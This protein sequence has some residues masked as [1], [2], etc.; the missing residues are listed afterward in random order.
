MR[1]GFRSIPACVLAALALGLALSAPAGAVTVGQTATT[2][3]GTCSSGIVFAQPSSASPS[4]TIPAGGG[5]IDHWS[6]ATFGATPGASVSLLVLTQLSATMYQVD[7][8]DNAAL[9]NPLPTPAGSAV[10]FTPATPIQAPAGA[11]LGL[12]GGTPSG[13]ECVFA[14]GANDSY[15]VGGP[16]SA[17]ANVASYTFPNPPSTGE[18]LNVAAD[19]VQN[20]DAG[21]TT[22]VAPSTATA[23]GVAAFTFT[24]TNSGVSTGTA[25]FSD[26]IP[27][28]LSIVSAAA[29]LGTCSTLSQLVSCSVSLPPGGSA[30]IS[31]VV[32]TSGAGTFTNTG[33]V[34]TS[35]TDPNLANNAATATL[36]VVAPPAAPTTPTTPTTPKP[37]CQVITL[38]GVPL[39]V[40]KSILRA[41]DCGVGKVSKRT[42][43]SVP[44][45]DVISTSPASGPH[46]A[47][48]NVAITVSSGKPKPKPKPKKHK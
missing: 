23:G 42:S 16:F 12:Y 27:N 17:P 18:R 1:N 35:L 26:S 11:V 15:S 7:S 46:P 34:T 10:T 13:A 30:P 22:A 20:V 28:G 37:S 41:L 4:Y 21:L 32:S 8:F 25:S 47:G 43:K 44:K 29:G 39:A 31:I 33:T 2:S 19:L 6:M 36:A 5:V 24:L 38:K 45:G 40:A 3:G 9:P 14:G 48:T